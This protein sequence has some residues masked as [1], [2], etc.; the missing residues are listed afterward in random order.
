MVNHG[1]GWGWV[2]GGGGS[3]LSNIA[4]DLSKS[5]TAQ[6]SNEQTTN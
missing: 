3:R 6:Q 5:Q 2:G 1:V 4:N